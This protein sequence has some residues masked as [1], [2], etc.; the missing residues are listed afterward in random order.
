MTH[1]HFSCTYVIWSKPWLC[2]SSKV[3]GGFGLIN[4]PK[5]LIFGQLRELALSLME[6]QSLGPSYSLKQGTSLT[7][8][9]HACIWEGFGPF[10]Q[11]NAS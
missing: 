2:W 7:R 1:F 10:G 8:G 3:Y 5:H 4:V 11:L 6:F 9:V